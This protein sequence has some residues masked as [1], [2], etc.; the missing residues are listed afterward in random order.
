MTVTMGDLVADTRRLAYGSMSDQLNFLAT[1]YLM[2]DAVLTMFLD[3][4]PIQPGM[5]LSSG[6]NVWY[7]MG[8]NP[9]DKT[10][11]VWASYQNSHNDALSSGAPVMIRPRVT[12]FVLFSYLNDVIRSMSAPSHGLYREGQWE[13]AADSIWWTYDIPTE[14]QDMV[15]LTRA[16]VRYPTSTDSWYELPSSY[17]EWQPENNVIRLKTTVPNSTTIRFDYKAPFAPAASL[18]DDIETVCGLS[19][20]MSDI[21]ALGAAARLLRTTES[22]R[23]QIHS[24]SDSRRAEEVG[25]GA[26]SDAARQMQR[27]F[28]DRIA[29]ERIRLVN[30][31][32][33]TLAWPR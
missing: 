23:S 6:L 26:N 5:V 21:P 15:A 14:A 18:T 24:Q 28:E 13:A 20:S 4:S 11:M 7:V 9:A 17:V 19:A 10:V 3:V 1:D 30:R 33:Y 2:G 29:Q 31:N 27:D 16:S 12:D 25:S 32:P 8:T 22:R